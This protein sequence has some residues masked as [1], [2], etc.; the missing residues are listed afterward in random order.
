MKPIIVTSFILCSVVA[1]ESMALCEPNTR[2]TGNALQTL[3]TGSLVCGRPA[4]GYTGSP[5]DRWQ[6]EHIAGGQLF[7]YKKGPSDT[8]D[9]RK[10]VGTWSI[11][12]N[13]V[14]YNYSASGP[15]TRTVHQIAGNTYSF[16]TGN[17]GA[18]VVRGFIGPNG[19]S[20]CGGS[21]P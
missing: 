21:F 19:G 7:D 4:A 8:V 17:N 13:Q 12:A 14:T 9:P 6:E 16:C 15:F 5:S 10:Q 2:V 11:A 20:G 1:G 3:L 18:E